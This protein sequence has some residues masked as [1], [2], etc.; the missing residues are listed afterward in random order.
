M[1]FRVWIA[2]VFCVF[3]PVVMGAGAFAYQ[4]P[5]KDSKAKFVY[6]FGPQGNPFDG[7]DDVDHEQV[8]YFDVPK[9]EQHD[10]VIKI[11]DPDTGGFRDQ[12]PFPESVWD[13]TVRF[14]VYG[15]DDVELASHEFGLSP[16]YDKRYYTFGPFPKE[17][18]RIMDKAYRFK[19]VAHAVKGED[20][21]LFAV[22]VSPGTVETSSDKISFR[23]L[24]KE[25]SAMYFYPE[26]PAGTVNIVVENFDLDEDGG[27]AKIIDISNGTT[28]PV[29][30]SGSGQWAQTPLSI[31]VSDV[32]R[33]LAYVITKK[34]Q[35]YANAAIRVKDDKGNILPI[36]FKKGKPV[37]TAK[38]E[39][40]IPGLKCNKF[41][42]DATKSYDPNNSKLSF[43]WDFGDG[44]MSTDP[45]VTHEYDQGGDYTVTLTVKN[46]SGLQCDTSSTSE[47]VK[48]NTPPQ[49]VFEVP[50]A[51]CSGDEFVFDASATTDNTPESLTYA[52][53]FGDGTKAEGK[54]FA[55]KFEKG[56]TYKVKLMV[57]DNAGTA[58]SSAGLE[59]TI[60]VNSSPVADAG[61]DME[62]CFGFSEPYH[63]IFDGSRSKDPD[64]DELSYTWDFGDG[65]QG[66]GKF[67]E[68]EYKKG[69]TYK[70][71]LTVDDGRGT[72]CSASTSQVMA[73]FNKQPVAHGGIEI[74]TCAGAAVEF[75][76]SA[77]RIPEG[78]EVVYRWDFGD[79]SSADGVRASHAYQ[80][81]GNY[82]A[83]LTVDDGK[84]FRCSSSVSQ[85]P[86][87]VNSGPFV[88]VS[89]P[90]SVCTGTQVSFD[91]SRSSD[92]D[93]DPLGFSWD[94][95]DGVT[96][97][98]GHKVTHTYEKG[99]VYSVKVTADDNRGT[100]CSSSSAVAAIKVNTPPVADA[101]RNQ[102]CCLG[103]ETPFDGSA[104][105][106]A[107]GDTLIY[108]WDFG[109]GA[110]AEGSKV[111]HVYAKSGTYTVTLTV[112]D[113]SGGP[114][115]S[116]KASF[117]ALVNEK[118]VPVI[119]VK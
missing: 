106:D 55:K 84:G 79:G 75:D 19:L 46:S 44:S 108:T 64:G 66:T 5:E 4:V 105:S 39:E 90:E 25:G 1:N 57:H 12:K 117:K 50:S 45:V 65:E 52:W 116:S 119:K 67:G 2:A 10:L 40:K 42:F 26:I 29:I 100:L 98:G 94:F 118:P 99:G 86:V 20:Q 8:F 49:P 115:S 13:T 17:K 114:C 104:S 28:Y 96:M 16:E 107:D 72:K 54:R 38:K 11:Y 61:D 103:I 77:S 82:T 7:A 89:C 81:G 27:T 24:P 21:N 36:Y 87:T 37:F 93:G 102:V 32:P 92:P 95:G 53:D 3:S 97:K 71:V 91:A 62:L 74:L 80:K 109:D 76:G 35:Q 68:H 63:V 85:V 111:S 56:G 33:R 34:T 9:D 43:L 59:K 41:T 60:A 14:T 6:V 101:G 18:G 58:C 51:V 112:D 15:S 73:K 83:S 70:V 47:V 110:V 48:A 22:D 30:G 78:S 113:N 69:G 23:L 31:G 88:H